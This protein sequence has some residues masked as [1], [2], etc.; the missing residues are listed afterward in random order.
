MLNRAEYDLCTF[1]SPSTCGKG[2]ATVSTNVRVWIGKSKM[3]STRASHN[4]R[5]TS[6]VKMASSSPVEKCDGRERNGV[7]PTKVRERLREERTNKQQFSRYNTID[8]LLPPPPHAVHRKPPNSRKSFGEYPLPIKS[9][10]NEMS[11]RSGRGG[12]R[13]RI[14]PEAASLC[15]RRTYRN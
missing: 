15:D 11:V 12:K 8:T 14:E 13:T 10:P 2:R 5:Q 1:P 4:G 9:T 7:W 3:S 6:V